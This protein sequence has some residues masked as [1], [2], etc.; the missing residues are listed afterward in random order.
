MNPFGDSLVHTSGPK[1]WPTFQRIADQSDVN[2]GHL[3]VNRRSNSW[4]ETL[5]TCFK[6]TNTCLPV[7]GCGVVLAESMCQKQS[8]AT[9][10]CTCS[11]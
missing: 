9:R 7:I 6:T 3:S 5:M 1:L 2:C 10:L 8:T 4:S 11:S